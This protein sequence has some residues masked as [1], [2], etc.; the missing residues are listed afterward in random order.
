MLFNVFVEHRG[1]LT[2]IDLCYHRH[3]EGD[4][5]TYS[6]LLAEAAACFIEGESMIGDP[7]ESVSSSLLLGFSTP[8]P[9]KLRLS[10]KQ[11]QN[12]FLKQLARKIQGSSS[13]LPLP[14]SFLNLKQT[15]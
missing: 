8:D 10:T 7:A 15:L 13:R 4:Y 14:L 5:S 11:K 12:L 6:C 9:A 2:F 3:C 1:K